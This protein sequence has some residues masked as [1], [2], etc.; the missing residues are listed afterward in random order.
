MPDDSEFYEHPSVRYSV[1]GFAAMIAAAAAYLTLYTQLTGQVPFLTIMYVTAVAAVWFWVLCVCRAYLWLPY[2]RLTASRTEGPSLRSILQSLSKDLRAK[3]PK[4]G[5]LDDYPNDAKQVSP[6]MW[7][8]LGE[9]RV[10]EWI[11]SRTSP[12]RRAGERAGLVLIVFGLLSVVPG[13]MTLDYQIEPYDG[14]IIPICVLLVLGTALV[15]V[16]KI[17][18]NDTAL[19]PRLWGEEVSQLWDIMDRDRIRERIRL[20]V[21]RSVMREKVGLVTLY[22]VRHAPAESQK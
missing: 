2:R 6:A 8:D 5:K 9:A 11:L 17:Y 10:I 20:W 7:S 1:Y 16:V 18:D 13:V 3:L 15:L 4:G 14:Y 21:E 12:I 22:A 19:A